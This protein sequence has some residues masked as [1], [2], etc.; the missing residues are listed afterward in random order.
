LDHGLRRERRAFVQALIQDGELARR[1][2]VDSQGWRESIQNYLDGRGPLLWVYWYGLILEI[3]LRL[4]TGRLPP[5][6]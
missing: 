1:G 4:R 6:G 3:W 5:S 2:Y